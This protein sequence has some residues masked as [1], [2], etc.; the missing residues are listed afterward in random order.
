M[1]TYISYS[2]GA[3]KTRHCLRSSYGPEGPAQ[4]GIHY[5]FGQVYM[6]TKGSS[7]N[8]NTHTLEP[9]RPQHDRTVTCDLALQYS[10]ATFASLRYPRKAR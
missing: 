9:D 3:I 7:W 2:P 8:P 6:Y 5:A 1:L 4:V 10:S